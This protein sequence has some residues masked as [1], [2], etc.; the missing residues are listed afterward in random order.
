MI[1]T[2]QSNAAILKELQANG[3]IPRVSI[4]RHVGVS[5]KNI[6][7]RFDKDNHYHSIGKAFTRTTRQPICM[8]DIRFAT[9]DGKPYE[10]DPYGGKTVISLMDANSDAI[11]AEGVAKCHNS[12]RFNRKQG[13]TVALKRAAKQ[14]NK[15][16]SK[17][18]AE[19]AKTIKNAEKIFDYGKR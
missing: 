4:M 5:L 7:V 13:F 11:Y 17:R 14:F 9:K 10:I 6:D 2:K 3:I 15:N 19:I 18:N 8:H 12:D 1:D 16:E